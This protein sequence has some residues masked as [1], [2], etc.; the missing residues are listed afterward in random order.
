MSGDCSPKEAV[1]Q[2]V[3]GDTVFS[4]L[5]NI[6]TRPA[7]TTRFCGDTEY[8]AQ[9]PLQWS[10]SLAEIAMIHSMDMAAKGHSSHTS[11]DGTSMGDRVF[12]YWN[13]GYTVG[14]NIAASSID[15][16]DQYVTEMWL[17][18]EGHCKLMMSRNSQLTPASVSGVTRKTVTP[19][20]TSGRWIS[21]ADRAAPDIKR[22]KSPVFPGRGWCLAPM[23]ITLGVRI[24]YSTSPSSRS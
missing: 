6:E 1:S 3:D 11:A 4:M 20:T 8:P 19:T 14:E 24:Y 12:P 22:H 16:D 10:A 13:A 23:Y 2:T 15:R 5:D 21:E 17:N 7:G 18:S 9:P